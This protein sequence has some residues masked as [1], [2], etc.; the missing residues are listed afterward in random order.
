MSSVDVVEFAKYLK[1]EILALPARTQEIIDAE[2]IEDAVKIII[3]FASTTRVNKFCKENDVAQFKVS[4]IKEELEE[5]LLAIC[6]EIRN[7]S[8]EDEEEESE[9]FDSVEDMEISET[10]APT[11]KT[12]IKNVAKLED[13][14]EIVTTKKTDKPSRKKIT[15]AKTTDEKKGKRGKA[16]IPMIE[17]EIDYEVMGLDPVIIETLV[18]AIDD[19]REPQPMDAIPKIYQ[20]TFNNFMG[21][22]NLTYKVLNVKLSSHAIAIKVEFGG[23][24]GSKD[25]TK[26][27]PIKKFANKK[28]AG[29][30]E[31]RAVA[32]SA[33]DID[34][35]EKD[36]LPEGIMRIIK[37][38]QEYDLM[39]KE[40]AKDIWVPEMKNILDS[41]FVYK[42]PAMKTE[43][44]MD[45]TRNL[46]LGPFKYYFNPEESK[47]YKYRQIDYQTLFSYLRFSGK[48]FSKTTLDS[49]MKSIYKHRTAI[50]YHDAVKD[51]LDAYWKKAKKQIEKLC[52]DNPCHV[53]EMWRLILNSN[54][55]ANIILRGYPSTTAFDNMMKSLLSEL[56]TKLLMM[57]ELWSISFIFSPFGVVINEAPK[58]DPI[59]YHKAAM[60]E[61]IEQ[62]TLECLDYK[63][64]QWAEGIIEEYEGDEETLLLSY[65]KI[66]DNH[67]FEP[68]GKG[69]KNSSTDESSSK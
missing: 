51:N 48:S 49:A 61:A 31:T 6:E 24:T 32:A 25:I 21:K 65:L 50:I 13:D 68:A 7:N 12:L 43:G 54:Q 34:K 1:K 47:E 45:T 67:I 9:K 15:T 56:D 2:D 23:N 4:S 58:K 64:C 27:M 36:S 42:L 18:T 59:K 5:E 16:V 46:P 63:K 55:C 66:K 40:G 35:I 10:V 41:D 52:K 39:F 53:N 20:S 19:V 14:E 62:A 3:K 69:D 38:F 60:N 28:I 44:F 26:A 11:K 17:G 33:Y 30:K 22:T 8:E 57:S 37:A 29:K